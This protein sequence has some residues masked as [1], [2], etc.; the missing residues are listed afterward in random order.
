MRRITLVLGAFIALGLVA[1][2]AQ[3]AERRI[4]RMQTL[5]VRDILYILQAGGGNTLA[6]M[7]DDGVVLVDTKMPGWGK[8]IR[9]T[10][11]SVTDKGVTTI[12]NTHAHTDH[13]GGNVDFPSATKII[14]HPNAKASM[15]KMA[16][17]S[18]PNAK[19]LPNTLVSDRLTLLDG[20]DQMDIYYFGRAHTNGDLVVVFPQKRLAHLGDL[21][22]GK[23]APIIDAANGGSA[24][25]FPQT[26][27]K[28][29][30]GLTGV[31]RITTGHDE[32]SA[33]PNNKDSGSA[34]FANPKVMT[35]RD[36]Q[37]Y[38]DFNNDFLSAVKQS[39]AD[40]KSAADAYT[41]L[42]LPD[43]YKD[44]DMRQAKA[45]VETIYKELGK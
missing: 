24:V 45:N 20:P 41:G 43:K 40:G 6:L 10:I 12:I 4:V 18:G 21:F 17:F 28:L 14:A 31:A 36:L 38:V 7:R 3:Q 35:M 22:P 39:I 29:V 19:F 2:S 37:E 13:T 9:D 42:K 23:A 25:E 33:I 27:A 11:E 16:Q 1:L 44:Y 26:L 8:S 30:A 15:E 32:S 5:N 34:I